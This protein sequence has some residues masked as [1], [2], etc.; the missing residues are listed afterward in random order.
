[1]PQ[2]TRTRPAADPF[3]ALSLDYDADAD[4]VRRAFRQLARETHPDR[5]GDAAAFRFARSAYDA[6]RSD[7]DGCRRRWAPRPAPRR[8]AGRISGPAFVPLD[9]YPGA[10]AIDP[11]TFPPCSVALRRS[12]A[13]PLPTVVWDTNSRPAGWRPGRAAP[14]GAA[15]AVRVEASE[16]GDTGRFGVWMHGWPSGFVFGP[17]PDDLDG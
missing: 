8:P 14:L 1:M 12:P 16:A 6:L 3:A 10:V 7:L 13:G 17:H 9:T 4:A 5:G 11:A 2:P 15:C